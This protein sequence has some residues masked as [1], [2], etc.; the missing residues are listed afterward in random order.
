MSDKKIIL[1]VEDEALIA[2]AQKKAL[3]KHGYGVI[4]AHS[5]EKAIEKVRTTPDIALILMDIN[6]GTGKMDG[7]ECAEVILK[8]R[9]IPVLFLSSYTQ[10]DIVE[11]TEKITSYGYVVKD[12]GETVLDA[13]IKMAFKL[14]K[15]KQEIK[16]NEQSL[17]KTN[18][19][20][21]LAQR[22]SGV[23]MWDWDIAG[24][25][26]EWTPQMFELFGLDK[27]KAPA[28]FEAWRN[29]VHPEDWANAEFQ[30]ERALKDH[31]FLSSEYRIVRP[32]GQVR[33]ISALG[34]GV[35]DT[36]GRPVCMAGTCIDITGR[37]Q[38]EDIEKLQAAVTET[39]TEGIFLIGVDDNIIKWTNTK[40]E[41]MFGY[42][43]G[44][45]IGMHV[46][47]VNAPT[48]KTPTETRVSI[49]DLLLATGEWHGEIKNIKKDGTYL[50]C[51]IH[52]SLFDHPEFG[53]VMVSAHTDITD[54]KQ[55]E[56]KLEFANAVLRTQQEN[57]LDG[58]LVVDENGRTVSFNRRFVDIWGIPGK[59]LE[60]GS[61]EEV[62]RSVLH[63]LVRPD[64][65][66]VKVR[67]LYEHRDEISRDEI[68]LIGDITLDRY[69]APMLGA[70]GEYYGRVWYFRDIT[71]RKRTENMLQV[72]LTKYKTMFDGFPLGITVSDETGKILESNLMARNLLGLSQEYHARRSI[73]SP[74]W[75]IIR[76]D[77]TLMP[78]DEYASVRALRE[79]R[80]VVNVE[81]GIVKPDE[82]VTW[83]SVTAAPLPI[84]GHG[85]VITYFDITE[86]KEAQERAKA[87][88]TKYRR[89]HETMTDA[90]VFVDMTGNIAEVNQSF[91]D[92]L[93]YSMEELSGLTYQ[94]LT[95]EKWHSFESNIINDQI[96]VR[97]FSDVYEKEYIR[98]DGTVFPVE[99]RTFLV[100]DDEGHPSELWAIVRDIT[101]RKLIEDKLSESN[102]L[103]SGIL[104]HTHMMAVF[105]DPRFNFIWVNRAYAETCGFDPS[106]FPGKNHFELY[107]HE[108]NKAIF[109]RVVDT[110]ESYFVAAKPFVFPDQPE[111]GVTYWDWSLMP[112]LD[113]GKVTGLV[114]TLSEVT[115]RINAEATLRE[116]E[117]RFSSAFEFAPIGV[118]L[119]STGGAFIKTNKALCNLLGYTAEEMPRLSFQEI[120]HPDDL[121][122][123]LAYVR[124]MLEGEIDTY[125]ME[126]RYFGKGGNLIWVLLSV[127]LVRGDEGHPQYFVSQIVDITERKLTEEQIKR[128]LTEKELLLKEVHHR[129]K[130]NM[131]VI[132]SLLSLQSD[133]LKDPSAV[134]AFHDT[135][136]RVRSMMV[137]YEKLYRSNDF[138]AI[139]AREYLAALVY[140]IVA[141]FPNRE[142]VDVETRVDDIALDAKILS[143]VGIIINELIT[144]TMK[145]AFTGMG[146]GRILV[147]FSMKDNHAKLIVE[148]NGIGIPESVNIETATGFGLQLVHIL[149]EQLEGSL[150]IEREDG[151]RFVLTFRL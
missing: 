54:R 118:A 31:V 67:Y 100:K 50:W 38:R 119:V 125:R 137:L 131:N 143:P 130:N 134:S 126:K 141:N 113:S 121:E 2:M 77:G 11:K 30:I 88:E 6:L 4:T 102:Q 144:N 85:V 99:L 15:A 110:G 49:V 17:S 81:M 27:D 149:V 106:S 66:L 3:E 117:A 116:S 29:I 5:G 61:D 98:K 42:S 139:S 136:N 123:D 83:L 111:R 140:E 145:Y 114:F 25:S 56:G 39:V 109:Q 35:Y 36:H 101:D 58:I 43:P 122:E 12:S 92:M 26:V 128:L 45:I 124:Q 72:T 7:T 9:D 150:R 107:P 79:R 148:D 24:G 44:E 82:A 97:G 18:E 14:H 8:E 34:R 105:L 93:G 13:S 62:L 135:E 47:K 73:D 76:P 33:W 90:L 59:A 52:V 95:P 147:F 142:R 19:R 104:D 16:E 57:S 70:N 51:Y 48:D 91:M 127:S 146:G 22:S 65:F 129:I 80:T 132:M 68:S 96:M 28:S 108:E 53:R 120:T 84:E 71:E 69:S 37:K 115:D 75:R 112:I 63:R 23:G 87:S 55:V 32:D 89:L 40:F 78:P 94:D 103:L 138:R 151:T 46:D 64:E 86:R 60:S 21:E 20:L 133:T 10:P 41:K 1:L 74:E